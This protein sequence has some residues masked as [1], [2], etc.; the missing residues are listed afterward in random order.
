MPAQEW[1]TPA[2][3]AY[4][5][6]MFAKYLEMSEQGNKKSSQRF[7]VSLNEGFFTRFPDQAAGDGDQIAKAKERLKTWMRYRE[8]HA[9][10][11]A[12]GRE[13]S[14]SGGGGGR[15]GKKKSLFQLLQKTKV[16]RP[17]RPVEVY[18]K[19]Y[20]R[21]VRGELMKRG[22]GDLNEEAEAERVA[23][24]REGRILTEEDEIR[25]EAEAEERVRQHRSMRL[26]M[27]RTTAIDMLNNESDEV[28]AEVQAEMV[29]LNDERAAGVEEH[30]GERTPEQYQH[31]I[32]QL[33]DVVTTLLQTIGEETGWHLCLLAGGPM[34]R[35]GGAI[36]TK[37]ICFG[38]T[39]L[40]QDFPAAHP[41]FEEAVK[42]HFN[43]YLKRAFPH[44]IRDAR[45]LATSNEADDT[46][47]SLEGLIAL[48][49]DD[50]DDGVAQTSKA[51]DKPKRVRRKKSTQAAAAPA[52]MEN[53]AT[54]M[55][56]DPTTAAPTMADIPVLSTSPS[57]ASAIPADFDQTMG[58]LLAATSDDGSSMSD[59]LNS[60]VWSDDEN[61]GFDLPPG[62]CLTT[63]RNYRSRDTSVDLSVGTA[64]ATRPPPRPI[65]TG[66]AFEMN[67]AIGDDLQFPPH[68]SLRPSALFQAFSRTP[69]IEPFITSPLAQQQQSSASET[70]GINGVATATSLGATKTPSPTPVPSTSVVSTPTT[71]S[72]SLLGRPT[73]STTPSKA[74]GIASTSHAV[75]TTATT[76][77]TA[78]STAPSTAAATAPAPA[79]PARVSWAAIAAAKRQAAA[80][81]LT[82]IASTAN[83][84]VAPSAAPP[85]SAPPASAAV[86]SAEATATANVTA[87]SAA[88]PS[89]APPASAPPASAAVPSAEATATT[90]PPS[91][92]PPASAAVPTGAE[93]TTAADMTVA[94]SAALSAQPQYIFSRPLANVPRGHPLAP[95]KTKKGRAKAAPKAARVNENS[96]PQMSEAAR[97][98]SARIR[99][100]EARMR[101]EKAELRKREKA[102]ADKAGALEAEEKRLA[103]LRHNPA[104]GADLFIVERPK[105]AVRATRHADGTPIVRPVRATRGE[106]AASA[107]QLATALDPNIV[108]E[109]V[110][111][112]LT[113]RLAG[114]KRKAADAAPAKPRT[115]KPPAFPRSTRGGGVATLDKWGPTR[116]TVGQGRVG[117][118]RKAGGCRQQDGVQEGTVSCRMLQSAEFCRRSGGCR[119][120]AARGAGSGVKLMEAGGGYRCETRINVERGENSR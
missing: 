81:A 89:A 79:P 48:D 57:F 61:L 11:S 18:Q 73:P 36:S 64:P 72:D 108:Q 15:G 51:S 86:P 59:F 4:L 6:E 12:A 87:P 35:R 14:T 33:G 114:K 101:K 111:E 105:R 102:M 40:G 44:E 27:T 107:T 106:L 84:V 45:G 120:R 103:A 71:S 16:T 77:P 56:A 82:A 93:A 10:A 58:S 24:S 118:G 113:R 112:D 49:P 52:T 76:P 20:G 3:K 97:I 78:P 104:G 43:K 50:N 119:G 94:P 62:S 32:D 23:A 110:D 54:T 30:D 65:H 25:E 99:G 13:S 68:L 21:R 34:P 2:Q 1:T 29:R 74:P 19:L 83:A 115:A 80:A 41:N 91:A 26:S 53:S 66:A 60:A 96:T 42:T 46:A 22:Y 7:W 47:P 17:Y 95:Q 85:A 9:R 8:R 38:T 90:T 55:A 37:S 5:V 98:E 69:R 109:Q 116:G 31:A 39:A 63:A 117:T 92:A 70:T 75:G 100:E 67:R 88:P 28:K